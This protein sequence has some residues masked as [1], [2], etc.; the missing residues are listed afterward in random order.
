[1]FGRAN[2]SLLIVLVSVLLAA[3]TGKAAMQYGAEAAVSEQV[4]PPP[5]PGAGDWT[6]VLIDLPWWEAD[7]GLAHAP[8]LEEFL[9]TARIV[10]GSG[11]P[12]EG[13]VVVTAVG[14]EG[15]S[16]SD[17]LVRM[18]VRMAPGTERLR[19]TASRFV[20]GVPWTGST[21]ADM[22]GGT[23]DAGDI[24]V[25]MRSECEPG[26]ERIFGM[27][28]RGG[29][30]RSNAI[31]FD[32]GY[33]EA[34]YVSGRSERATGNTPGVFRWNG[35][36]WSE[37]GVDPEIEGIVDALAIFD[38]GTGPALY[39][40]GSFTSLANPGFDNIARWN[41]S[42]WSTLGTGLGHQSNFGGVYTLAVHNDGTGDAL[43][44]GG[45]FT[46]VGGVHG[47][48]RIARWDGADWTPLGSGLAGTRTPPWPPYAT[49]A[50]SFDDGSGSALYVAGNFTS[51]GGVPANG[52]ARWDGQSWSA[53]DQGLAGVTGRFVVF[54]DGSG[55]SLYA[56]TIIPNATEN[57]GQLV[58]WSG[59]EWLPVGSRIPH[60]PGATL[61]YNTSDGPVILASFN[62]T[63]Q[64]PHRAEIFRFDGVDWALL[65]DDIEG[66]ITGLTLFNHGE[67]D[68]IIFVG[69]RSVPGLSSLST[70]ARLTADGWKSL[71]SN[72][73]EPVRA[74]ALHDDGSGEAFFAGGDFTRTGSGATNHVARWDGSNWRNLGD[75]L[76]GLVRSLVRF[77]DGTGMHL[78]A[79]GDFDSSGATQVNRIARWD[80]T[81]WS[82]LG[83]G[84]ANGNV[85]TLAVFDDGTGPALYAGG[86]FTTAGGQ[87][88]SR[89]AKWDGTT[90]SPMS[91]GFSGNAV[92]HLWVHDDGQGPSLYAAGDFTQSQHTQLNHMAR[93]S[94]QEWVPVGSGFDRWVYS[95]TTFDDGS[96]P[97]LIAAGRFDTAGGQLAPRIAKWDGQSWSRVGD[98]T[99]TASFLGRVRVR[100]ARAGQRDILLATN[101][102]DS[103]PT[104]DRTPISQWDG[105]TWSYIAN[106]ILHRNHPG[107]DATTV[108]ELY[109]HNVD[110]EQGVVV[111]GSFNMRGLFSGNIGFLRLCSPPCIPDING[112]GVVDADDF[113]AF[114]SLFASGDLRAD[115]NND[116]VIDADDFFAF[117][118][119]FAA[120]C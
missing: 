93:W 59:T 69:A 28:H 104:V 100:T 51:A 70:I 29:F 19:V 48:N 1:M 61:T 57:R 74:V 109:P 117:L 95:M 11:R 110:G 22:T 26:L 82:P 40:A 33:G 35:H 101:L 37:L 91:L 73:Y 83:A 5:H 15:V 53:A 52:L 55:P 9:V 114:L 77:D 118:T 32:G 71:S 96:G 39:C 45:G 23:F 116:G 85:H 47:F 43:Y 14:E 56:H 81:S 38:D 44:V 8:L 10:D 103:D 94:G 58:K 62:Y 98:N 30:F 86:S 16:D 21:M 97:K 12:V 18:R 68:E 50:I 72:M 7:I 66:S 92:H 120:G 99:F 46:T 65:Y 106:D 34:L 88:A 41:G 42:Q 111:A 54:D 76:D 75:G 36:V 64:S 107:S 119:L 84:L 113:F 31:V 115:I 67:G 2:G 80:G 102:L 17:G 87:A 4:A 6:D 90:W 3:S 13:A 24:P 25:V 78:Y 63:N 79:G 20:D 105:S 108:M 89:V 60:L 112:D 27:A 49:S